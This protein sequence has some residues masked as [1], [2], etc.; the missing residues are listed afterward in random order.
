MYVVW[1]VSI[2]SIKARCFCLALATGPF[3]FSWVLGEQPGGPPASPSTSCSGPG[4]M[5][6]Q[7][8]AQLPRG[9]GYCIEAQ[10]PL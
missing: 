5:A 8:K 4:P 6:W 2:I 3:L 7:V 9:W 1:S 10:G